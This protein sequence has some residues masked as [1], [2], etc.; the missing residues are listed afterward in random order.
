MHQS[1][2]KTFKKFQPILPKDTFLTD[3]K[4]NNSVEILMQ[5]T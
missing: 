5:Y 4:G 1:I 3:I 2:Y